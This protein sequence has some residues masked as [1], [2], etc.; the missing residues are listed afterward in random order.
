MIKNIKLITLA[1]TIS[2]LA[3]CAGKK[4][5][6]GEEADPAKTENSTSVTV[7]AG[8]GGTVE[9]K[10]D[11]GTDVTIDVDKKGGSIE[12]KDGDNK[13]DIEIKDDDKKKKDN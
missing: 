10:K 5:K 9:V 4:E 13:V 2:I 12:V 6:T 7:E 8:D 3:A 1:V 11:D